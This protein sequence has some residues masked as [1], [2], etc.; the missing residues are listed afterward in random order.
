[1]GLQGRSRVVVVS[2]LCFLFLTVRGYAL[3]WN[4]SLDVF[5]GYR[6]D[7]LICWIDD[8]DP[9]TTLVSVDR[10][11]ARDL[12]IYETGLNG[13]LTICD[14]WLLRGFLAYGKVHSGKYIEKNTVIGENQVTNLSET[15]A[16]AKVRRGHTEDGSIGLGYLFPLFKCFCL[17]DGA[18]LGPV[19]G[20]AFHT[21]N[22]KMNSAKS[23]TFTPEKPDIVFSPDPT[24]DGLNYKNRWRS[25]WL[26]LEVFLPI[27]CVNIRIG[28][29][30]HWPRWHAEWLLAGNDVP[31]AAFS[32]RRSAEEGYG[33]L[34]FLNASYYLWD[35]FYI[36]SE[37]NFHYWRVKDGKLSPKALD[38]VAIGIK[39]T[40]IFEVRKAVWKSFEVEVSIGYSF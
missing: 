32:D 28:Y 34:A 36:A 26:G 15:I 10:L 24:L 23:G 5:G 9:P 33:S 37:V 18:S 31:N 27:Y 8:F 39:D 20:W 35:C 4:L 16:K 25:F 22:I 30:Y 11:R 21:Q 19:F 14:S 12:E 3:E 1:M 6:T 13:R 29:E 17:D 40:E 2:F 7:M 38:P